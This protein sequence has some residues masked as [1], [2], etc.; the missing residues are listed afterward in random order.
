MIDR[1][2]C[3]HAEHALGPDNS[4]TTRGL[5]DV[6]GDQHTGPVGSADPGR[7]HHVLQMDAIRYLHTFRNQ[8]RVSLESARNLMLTIAQLTKDQL[9]S[10]LPLLGRHLAGE[11]VVVYTYAAVAIDRILAISA[12]G[13]GTPL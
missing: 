11:D 2:S 1:S 4:G 13:S 8:V 7:V 6:R 5:S 12:P 9:S 3:S 10:V